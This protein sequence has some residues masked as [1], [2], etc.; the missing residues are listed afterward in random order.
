M[1]EPLCEAL[2]RPVV[3]Q[4]HRQI[5]LG[6]ADTAETTST[7]ARERTRSILRRIDPH[8]LAFADAARATFGEGV[9]LTDVR[10]RPDVAA[11]V[12]DWLHENGDGV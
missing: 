7:R 10:V 12:I 9:K 6:A 3:R 5:D 8:M 4:E 11:D 1:R 2:G